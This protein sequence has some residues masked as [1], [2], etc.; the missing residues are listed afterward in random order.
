M[1]GVREQALTGDIGV[2]A[3]MAPFAFGHALV[4]VTPS[5]QNTAT[6]LLCVVPYNETCV[7]KP[8]IVA[9]VG[10]IV[11]VYD[12]NGSKTNAQPLVCPHDEYF[13]FRLKTL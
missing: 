2:V 11:R 1:R 5:G 12:G 13:R 8:A 9:L 4:V 3:K 6:K 10:P 7:P